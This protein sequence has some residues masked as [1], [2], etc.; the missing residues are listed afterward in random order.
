L[1]SQVLTLYTTPVIYIW[2]DRLAARLSRHRA[3][4]RPATV[5]DVNPAG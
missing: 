1:I 2:F 4:D 3:S 5:A